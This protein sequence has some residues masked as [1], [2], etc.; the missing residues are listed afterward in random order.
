MLWTSSQRVLLSSTGVGARSDHCSS[1]PAH[2]APVNL[3]S[4]STHV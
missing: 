3:P 4:S 1:G 2:P